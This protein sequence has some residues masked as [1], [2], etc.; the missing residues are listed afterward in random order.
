MI[1]EI[2]MIGSALIGG[3]IGGV[4]NYC[5]KRQSSLVGDAAIGAGSCLPLALLFL[6]LGLDVNWEVIG[7]LAC[8]CAAYP[9]DGQLARRVLG[10]LHQR[11]VALLA[12]PL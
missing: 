12:G 11:L 9:N 4:V 8:L 1:N 10:F 6:A 5:K 2:V 7:A 3:A